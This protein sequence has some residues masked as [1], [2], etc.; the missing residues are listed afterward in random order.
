[1]GTCAPNSD[2]VKD[3]KPV[4]DG[5]V[6]IKCRYLAAFLRLD[7]AGQHAA[8]SKTFHHIFQDSLSRNHIDAICFR[9]FCQLRESLSDVGDNRVALSPQKL[10]MPFVVPEISPSMHAPWSRRKYR[11]IRITAA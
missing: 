6:A 11:L 4:I 7:L 9:E 5:K 3:C 10:L 1:M 8:A 2:R